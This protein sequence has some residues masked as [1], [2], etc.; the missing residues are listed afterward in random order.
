[1]NIFIWLIVPLLAFLVFKYVGV[2]LYLI[3]AS[4]AYLAGK[5]IDWRSKNAN[6]QKHR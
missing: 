4:A 2:V 5:K 3:I 6:E 1:M